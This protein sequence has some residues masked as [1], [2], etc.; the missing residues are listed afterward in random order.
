MNVTRCCP[1]NVSGHSRNEEPAWKRVGG[2]AQGGLR[3]DRLETRTQAGEE[4]WRGHRSM[5][6]SQTAI[7]HGGRR[8]N[9]LV[10][11]AEVACVYRIA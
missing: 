8:S 4:I 9:I 11:A 5:E 2:D 7:H 3:L 10:P 6:D 1:G